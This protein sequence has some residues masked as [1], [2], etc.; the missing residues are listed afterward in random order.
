M[1]DIL[2]IALILSGA[3]AAIILCLNAQRICTLLNLMDVP[4]GRKKHSVPTPL[5]G[6]VTL[7]I[8]FV[9]V[10][11]AYIMIFASERWLGSLLIWLGCVS[12]MALVGLG[13]DRHS[14][15]PRSRLIISFAVFAIAAAVDPTFNVRVLDFI[16]PP[17]TLGLGTWWLSIIFTVVC[18][19]GLLNAVNMADGKNGLVLG[20]SLGWLA[21]LAT[22]SVGPLL[23]LIGLFSAVL[24]VLFTFNMRSKLFLGDG[25]AYAIA[26]AIG[27]LSIMVYNT[28]GTQA[29]RAISAD[30]L[31]LLFVVP[32]AD[33]FR[34]T[35]K[36]LRQGRSPM[37]A[38]RDHLH[39][40]LQDKFGWPG[41]LFMYWIASLTLA[42]I[43][44][45]L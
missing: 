5:M 24:M 18:C 7:L 30:E 33:S 11:L 45:I 31:V 6:G 1:D 27:L 15:S 10:A 25:G 42:L 21:I 20:L 36:R 22:R 32:V 38:D 3:L 39:H 37:S 29:L 17:L 16:I 8:A 43:L 13:D 28:P 19:V 2:Y 12:A 4:V 9:P 41:G 26:A 34:L 35:Y 23:P 14:L 40:H 44:I